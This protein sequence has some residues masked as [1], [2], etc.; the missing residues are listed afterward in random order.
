[1]VEVDTILINQQLEYVIDSAVLRSKVCKEEC[2]FL[3]G[4]PDLLRHLLT[5]SVRSLCDLQR[6]PSIRRM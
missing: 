5:N 2:I 6:L 4:T 1:M 3:V